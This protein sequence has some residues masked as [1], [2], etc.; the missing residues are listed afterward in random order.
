MIR[1]RD[2]YMIRPLAVAV[3]AAAV[4]LTGTVAQAVVQVNADH[5]AA[6]STVTGGL[7]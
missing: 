4:L 6:Y 3:A 5:L 1:L 2:R 7:P